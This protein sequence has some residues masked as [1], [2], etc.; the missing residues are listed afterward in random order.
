MH[1]GYQFL[2]A[3]RKFEVPYDVVENGRVI[4]KTRTE[5][6]T[7]PNRS[8]HTGN[9]KFF[10]AF[11]NLGIESSLRATFRGKFGIDFN[12][13]ERIDANEYVYTADNLEEAFDKTILDFSL[14]KTFYN[15]VRLMVGI[16]NITDFTD[17]RYLPS[18]PGR[19][20]YTQLNIKLH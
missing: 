18:N 11:E 20:F 12:G 19:T 5:Y 2:D 14:A 10:Y 13:N 1:L 4:S 3:R 15:R 17:A 8:K 9:L 7:L 16:D 6:G